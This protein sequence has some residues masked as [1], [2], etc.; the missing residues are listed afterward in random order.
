MAIEKQSGYKCKFYG[1][2]AAKFLK[3]GVLF[4]KR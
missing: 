4:I 3:F 2:K 1:L